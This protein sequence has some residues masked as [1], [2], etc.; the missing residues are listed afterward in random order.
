MILQNIYILL[1]HPFK[2]R[3][4]VYFRPESVIF[5]MKFAFETICDLQKQSPE[6]F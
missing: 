5:V 3:L 6:M 1:P 4:F 2:T